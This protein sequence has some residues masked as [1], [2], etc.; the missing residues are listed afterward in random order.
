VAGNFGFSTVIFFS[1]LY[2][3]DQLDLAPLQAGLAMLAFSICFVVTLPLAGALMRRAG[4]RVLMALGMALIAAAS[5]LFLPGGLVWLV[6]AL[7][8]A[9]AGQGFAF[10][11]S[12]TAAMDA[13]PP[14][15]SGAAAGVLNAARQL[16]SILGIAVAG[17]VFQTLESRG[18]LAAMHGHADLDAQRVALIRALYAGSDAA[19]ATLAE[20]APGLHAEVAAAMATVFATSFQGA[21]VACAVVSLAGVAVALRVPKAPQPA[22]G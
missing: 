18:L 20:L 16:G 7:G 9:G 4:P 22:A 15:R 8:V 5:L 2:L 11:T 6:V 13:V 17:A 1:A 12:T 21:M 10:N 14:A 3:Q 19:R